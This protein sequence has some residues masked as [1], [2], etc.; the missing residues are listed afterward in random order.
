MLF[1]EILSVCEK[2]WRVFLLLLASS[3][4]SSSSVFVL[5]TQFF[6]FERVPFI[7]D[8]D[9]WRRFPFHFQSKNEWELED[10]VVLLLT[11]EY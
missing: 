8:D 1:L 3:V 5:L 11:P 6:F 7:D 4:S 10:S 2:G 9:G